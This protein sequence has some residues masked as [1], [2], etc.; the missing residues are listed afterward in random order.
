MTARLVHVAEG[1]I[2]IAGERTVDLSGSN[3][4]VGDLSLEVLDMPGDRVALSMEL[5]LLPVGVGPGSPS[6]SD[7][8]P[9]IIDKGLL[10]DSATK[11]VEWTG[12][13]LDRNET[14]F[15][16]WYAR[17][18]KSTTGLRFEDDLKSMV[19]ASKQGASFVV[20]TLGWGG[21]DGGTPSPVPHADLA[22]IRGKWKVVSADGDAAR[23][24]PSD[25]DF[26]LE[27]T[28]EALTRKGEA[29]TVRRPYRV[30]PTTSPKQIDFLVDSNGVANIEERGVYELDGD[31]LR[32]A[33]HADKPSRRPK[34]FDNEEPG[35]AKVVL[36]LN[37]VE[38]GRS[39]RRGEGFIR[40]V[41]VGVRFKRPPLEAFKPEARKALE[42]GASYADQVTAIP[43]D[44]RSWVDPSDVIDTSTLVR[45]KPSAANRT[46]TAPPDLGRDEANIQGTWKIVARKGEPVGPR[47]P[48]YGPGL[49]IGANTL[50]GLVGEDQQPSHYRID[51]EKTPKWID[52]VPVDES[53]ILGIYELDGDSIRLA[54]TGGK[55]GE[56][57]KSFTRQ[58][59]A[60][61]VIEFERVVAE[62]SPFP[63]ET[64]GFIRGVPRG[65]A[66]RTTVA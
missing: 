62:P 17:L 5:R 2:R 9:L 18:P 52:I 66:L 58:R 14:E 32:L 30:G 23:A 47:G 49:V 27:F 63:G 45:K 55:Q 40:G 16:H 1:R 3:E 22:D 34:S 46:A 11:T 33:F 4:A 59:S 31:T 43:F 36:V 60:I 28:A 13:V 29:N 19:E 25:Y 41:P 6:R 21:R 37:R 24:R 10:A 53:A 56:R 8:E 35:S 51:A 39:P 64:A 54:V 50:K 26:E 57:P 12:E 20:V 61:V 65:C 7:S 44:H 48:W 42:N 38:V 15:V